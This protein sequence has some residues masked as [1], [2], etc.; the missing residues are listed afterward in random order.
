[1]FALK[2]QYA[3][4]DCNFSFIYEITI[5]VWYVAKMTRVSTTK[6]KVTVKV[7]TLPFLYI[8]I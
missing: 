6:V 4:K 8:L 7:Q 5:Y 1:V 2:L 3:W